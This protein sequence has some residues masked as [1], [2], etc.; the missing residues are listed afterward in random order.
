[1]VASK[2]TV[3]SWTYS[4]EFIPY[5]TSLEKEDALLDVETKLASRV[6]TCPE[7]GT[8]IATGR[9]GR[10]LQESGVI[11]GLVGV[12]PKPYDILDNTAVCA[13]ND[14][15]IRN[16]TDCSI[17]D[18]VMTAFLGRDADD[19]GVRSE[20][21]M[22]I[23]DVMKSDDF[24]GIPS[25]VRVTYLEP[26][27]SDDVVSEANDGSLSPST[28]PA[29]TQNQSFVVA[30]TTVGLFIF[31]AISLVVYR[32]RQ[33]QE[34]DGALAVDAVSG[35]TTEISGTQQRTEDED[36]QPTSPFSS[37]L[38]GCYTMNGQDAM[39]A[40]LEGDSSDSESRTQ[41]S[42]LLS[43]GGYTTDG[44]SVQDET[45]NTSRHADPVLGVQ[46]V[47]DDDFMATERAFLFE[48]DPPTDEEI[49]KMSPMST[50]DV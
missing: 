50:G 49:S 23:S 36:S 29:P 6:L 10:I 14:T 39:S 30:F 48:S 46:K 2:A 19:Q 11:Q 7:T 20:M 16:V 26:S 35:M 27:L 4:V 47:D 43:D 42:V 44:D 34:G 33:K 25:I 8:D 45:Y 17:Y 28:I 15:S 1:M 18:G 41:S 9:G 5:A 21:L 38:P 13:S 32:R 12:D 40:I 22:R 3:V 24:P 31:I 37:M